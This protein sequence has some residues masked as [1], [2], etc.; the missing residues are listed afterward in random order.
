LE[1]SGTPGT[2]G[3]YDLD[4]EIQS[5]RR[6]STRFHLR[7]ESDAASTIDEWIVNLCY[8]NFRLTRMDSNE[9]FGRAISGCLR[10]DELARGRTS[11]LLAW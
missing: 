5:P 9:V 10:P 2:A 3:E 1:V 11:R 8:A 4:L 6:H 7:V